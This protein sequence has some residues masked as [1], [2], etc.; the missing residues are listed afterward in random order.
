MF[1]VSLA[2]A[3]SD[4]VT[5]A[6][7]TSG[8]TATSGTDFTAASGTLTFAANETSKTVSVAT[9]DDATDEAN[10]TFTLTL[11]SPTNATLGTATATGTINDDDD[12]EVVVPLTAAFQ[13]VP[14]T[15]DGSTAFTLQ[16]LFSE[17][18]AP[19][20]SGRKLAQALTLTGATRGT[21]RRVNER[22]DLYQFPVQ[23]SG[24]AAVTVAL[25]ATSDCAASDAVCTADGKA[26]SNEPRATVAYA[27]SS[28][29]TAEDEVE[30]ALALVAGL[31]PTEATQALFGE[32]SLTVAQQAAL[33]RLGN[34]N[35]RFDLGDV[36][37][38]IER[39]QR[40]E[41]RCGGTSLDAGPAGAALLA[42]V[43]GRG[44]S[45]RTGGRAAGPRGR[46]PMRRARRRAGTAGYLLAV[47]LAAITIWSCT[48]GS[49]APTTVEP[50]PGS[51]TVEL[52]A[53][54]A[55]RDSGVLLELEGPGIETVQ[56]PGLELYESRASGRHQII[57]MGSLEAG[58]LM[59]FRVPD[60]NQLPL[61]RVRVVQVTGEDYRLRD[62]GE[63]RAVI[64]KL[65]GEPDVRAAAQVRPGGRPAATQ[66]EDSRLAPKKLH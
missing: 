57:L 35:G 53:P 7:A 33:D 4:Q 39:C 30:D 17:A 66:A 19:G 2:P 14:A 12:G 60:R 23:P 28:N 32:R 20:G 38:W 46:T 43:R 55:H 54:A 56:A 10:E 16:V 61:Y 21:V 40:G 63:Y 26:L 8:G 31:T 27:A 13:N 1:T 48:D 29:S 18:L 50:D 9:T 42:A 65:T 15:H 36:R 59:Q 11:S 51:L 49:V 44:T 45:G 62:A 37:A 64:T 22:R 24:T 34:Q 47:L 58:P 6:Y 25:S 41:A 3:S 52:T 5:V